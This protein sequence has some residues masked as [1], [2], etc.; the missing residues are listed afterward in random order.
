MTPAEF[1]RKF[2]VLDM[3]L[4]AH[5]ALRESYWRRSTALTLT[6]IALS[7]LGVS[8]ALQDDPSVEILSIDLESKQ[9]L[10][11]LSGLVFFL[12]I[13]ELVL[14]WRGRA[15]AHQY[16]AGRLASLKGEFRRAE[17]GPEAVRGGADLDSDYERTT[18]AIA[19]IPNSRFNRLKA[20][21]HRKVAV[22]KMISKSPGTPI[23]VLRWR[24]LR[25]G[26]SSDDP[27]T[28]QSRGVLEESPPSPSAE[29]SGR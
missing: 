12:S 20:R 27:P 28:Q 23:P 24:L 9:W 18:A 17:V 15:W 14:D 2:E 11:I 19:E 22:S 16:A 3:M 25:E 8:L 29:R 4:S 7:I 13:A 21:H 5:S 10:A 1:E 26:T 6:I